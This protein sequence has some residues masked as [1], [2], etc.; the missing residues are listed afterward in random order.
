MMLSL[1]Q[2]RSDYK[3]VYR[4]NWKLAQK[5]EVLIEISKVELSYEGDTSQAGKRVKVSSI[6]RGAQITLRTLQRWKEAYRKKGIC[7]LSPKKKGGVKAIDLSLEVQEL[8]TFFRS[9]YRWGSEVIQAHLLK[10]K[11]MYVTRYKIERYLTQSGLKLKYPCSTIKKTKAKEKKHI[12]KVVVHHPGEHTQ[13]DVKYQTHLLLNKEK[14]YVY[15]FVDHASNWS[16]KKAY[17]AITAK[18]T[19]EFVEELLIECPFKIKRL[20]TDNGIEFTYKWTSKNA[21]DPKEHP[22]L[23]ICAREN[24]RHVLIPPGEKELQ[25]LVE[26]SHR[27]DDQE[28]FSRIRPLDLAEFN[29]LLKGYWLFRNRGRRFKKLSWESPDSWLEGYLIRIL[30][31][32]LHIKGKYEDVEKLVA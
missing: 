28:L 7:G 17:S 2:L 27:Q 25:G 1:V 21:D 24:I 32:I 12:K 16:F 14:S 29:G 22:L 30:G 5:L 11:K 20:Q 3:A 9:N 6:L 4:S 15:N 8:I 18:N 10:D 23:R 26:R 31:V 13:M 19:S